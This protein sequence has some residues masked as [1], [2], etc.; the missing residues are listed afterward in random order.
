MDD[1]RWC[2]VY[3]EMKVWLISDTH[4]QHKE[5]NVPECD[6]VIHCGDES[7]H[8]SP[9]LNA[10]EAEKFFEWF[11]QLDIKHKVFIPG[12]HST[13]VH[14]GLVKPDKKKISMLIHQSLEIEGLRIFGSPFTPSWGKSGAYMR[15]RNRMRDIWDTM[16]DCDILVTHGPPQGILDIAVTDNQLVQCGCKSLLNK[17][18]K[19]RPKYHCFGHLHDTK[20]VINHAV[21]MVDNINFVNCA[22]KKHHKNDIHNGFLLTF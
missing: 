9:A 19:I 13:S 17:V 15:S 4:N 16:D 22:C 7:N 1:R 18:M 21:K 14:A 8:Y 10:P 11:T 6:M 5:L 3:G 2:K 20:G 12:N